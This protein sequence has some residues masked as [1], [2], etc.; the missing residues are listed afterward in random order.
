[1]MTHLNLILSAFFLCCIFYAFI[2]EFLV[3][4]LKSC[5][6][7]APSLVAEGGFV[8]THT[9][10]D[11]PEFNHDRSQLAMRAYDEGV[12][13][14]V[15]VG[16]LARYFERMVSCQQALMTQMQAGECVPQAHLAFG[17]HPFYIKEHT[18]DDLD[19]LQRALQNH[20]SIAIGEIGLDTFS[21]EMKLDHHFKKQQAFFDSQL[22]LAQTHRL[23]VLLHIR[24][25]H[26]QALQQLKSA[27]FDCG[28]IAHSFSG[29]IQEAK[30]F[31]DLG[32]KIGV[33]GQITNP[34][35]KKLRT[36]ISELVKAVGLGSLV[37][38]TDCPDFTPVPCHASHGR[39][40]SPDTLPYVAHELSVLLGVQKE[41]VMTALW[42][43]SMNA[44]PL[45]QC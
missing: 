9:H 35:A 11:V 33:T 32:F 13:H 40:N 23:P 42:N 41:A 10:F 34:N 19:N 20:T 27:G 15:L 25:A 44:L 12:R 28:G 26:A 39:R 3:M 14:L 6:S 7:F 43:N 22:L 4:T 5:L 29:G 37:I 31:V 18:T 24:K 38:E 36:T 30:A 21:D 45:L 17:L 2:D 8:D 16:Y 1:M